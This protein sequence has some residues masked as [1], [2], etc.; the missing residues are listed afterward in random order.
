[1]E[2]HR[3]QPEKRQ[4]FQS[5]RRIKHNDVGLL[6]H[7]KTHTAYASSV[8]QLC[9]QPSGRRVASHCVS[10]WHPVRPSASKTCE[11]AP[12]FPTHQD[13]KE[14]KA[15][16]GRAK[17]QAQLL[18]RPVKFN[19]VR[20]GLPGAAARVAFSGAWATREAANNRQPVVSTSWGERP[21][22]IPF[23]SISKFPPANGCSV[24]GA[25]RWQAEAL[26]HC[27]RM[28]DERR[29]RTHAKAV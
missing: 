6:S 14:Q 10:F 9:T 3:D 29:H 22:F 21:P 19:F 1:V 5:Q 18:L 13:Q 26:E 24:V 27:D 25:A 8:T 20:W 16:P 28:P 23:R 15:L 11:R 17:A 12:P 7:P 4:D 2:D